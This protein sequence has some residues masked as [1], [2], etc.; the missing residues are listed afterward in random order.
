MRF[1]LSC[2]VALLAVFTATAQFIPTWNVDPSLFQQAQPAA[3]PNLFNFIPSLFPQHTVNRPP[4]PLGW[5]K[6]K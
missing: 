6:K 4:T 3:E 1:F 2:F 5:G